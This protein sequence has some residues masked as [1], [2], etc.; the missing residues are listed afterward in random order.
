MKTNEL[1]QSCLKFLKK[2]GIFAYRQNNIATQG[3]RHNVH[4]GTPDIIAIYKGI[5]WGIEIKNADTNDK[6]SIYQKEF[7]EQIEL[8][9]G[10]YTVVTCLDDLINVYNNMKVK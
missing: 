7:Q 8:S 3:R 2:V 1:T 5:F 10:I 6:Q 4:K 9:G